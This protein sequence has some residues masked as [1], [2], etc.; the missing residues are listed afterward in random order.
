MTASA[1]AADAPAGTGRSARTRGTSI[2]S[3][4]T[5]SYRFSINDRTGKPHGY[6]MPKTEA[7]EHR[8]RYRSEILAGTFI[9][10]TGD[11][12]HALTFGDCCD[13][14]VAEYVKVPTRT[15][16]SERQ[17]VCYL[18]LAR[19]TDVPAANGTTV[20]LEQKAITDVT[21]ADIK[22]LCESRLTI[23]GTKAAKGTDYDKAGHVGVNRLKARVR[24]VT[25]PSSVHAFVREPM[26]VDV[27][28]DSRTR[29]GRSQVDQRGSSG[30]SSSGTGTR[31]AE[32]S[33][34][35]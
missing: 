30:V 21:R 28:V 32:S 29:P 2:S 25:C 6:V 12:S 15:A 7:R 13:R 5:G 27:P 10:G 18:N 4:T 11:P 33:I 19:R 9:D 35:A 23:A 17:F 3:T 14:Y 31:S 24:R 8:D 1:N 20:R 34:R 16:A 26:K 22:A